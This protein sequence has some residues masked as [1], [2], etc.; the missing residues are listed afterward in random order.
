MTTKGITKR[1]GEEHDADFMIDRVLKSVAEGEIT[2]AK[3]RGV[4]NYNFRVLF[5]AEEDKSRR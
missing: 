4:L 5:E 2:P 1:G 3:A